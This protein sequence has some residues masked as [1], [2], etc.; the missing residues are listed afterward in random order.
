MADL[1]GAVLKTELG[2]VMENIHDSFSKTIYAFIDKPDEDSSNDNDN[3]LFERKR[4]GQTRKT[5]QELTARIKYF[6]SQSEEISNLNL[7][8][9]K[10]VVRIKVALADSTYIQEASEIEVEGSLYNRVSDPKVIGSLG[11]VYHSYYL[12]RQN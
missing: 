5:K 2:G 9:S 3:P 10:G 1:I 4:R 7:P 6:E 12:V 8:M 11:V